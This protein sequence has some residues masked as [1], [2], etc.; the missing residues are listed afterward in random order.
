MEQGEGEIRGEDDACAVLGR[1]GAQILKG[2]VSCEQW[3]WRERREPAE[4]EQREKKKMR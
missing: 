1:L 4:K 2:L 3:K